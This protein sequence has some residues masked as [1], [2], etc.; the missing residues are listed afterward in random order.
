MSQ[1][2][3]RDEIRQ[4]INNWNSKFPIDYWWR[5]KYNIPFGSPAHRDANLIDMFYDYEEEK[6]M[7]KIIES[8][9]S[10]EEG[11]S[12]ADLN[13]GKKMS[14][15]ELDDAFDNLDVNQFNSTK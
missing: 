5:K 6:I 7:N 10:E 4:Q 14:N 3:I 1:N 11:E 12:V 8:M 15:K 9:T 2:K 13:V